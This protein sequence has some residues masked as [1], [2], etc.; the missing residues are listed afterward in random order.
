MGHNSFP[1]NNLLNIL[2][3]TWG[4]CLTPKRQRNNVVP[5]VKNTINCALKTEATCSH[6]DHFTRSQISHIH[7]P[8]AESV[9]IPLKRPSTCSPETRL[10]CRSNKGFSSHVA[11]L[12]SFETFERS[13]W[14]QTVRT[15]SKLQTHTFIWRFG[16]INR[17]RGERVEHRSHLILT[18]NWTQDT[19]PWHRQSLDQSS[20]ENYFHSQTR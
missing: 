18:E 10:L 1:L 5:C 7:K 20:A 17:G 4:S 16:S 9:F 14:L 2:Y 12:C 11:A 6:L 3:I 19:Q 13:H 15:S 8:L